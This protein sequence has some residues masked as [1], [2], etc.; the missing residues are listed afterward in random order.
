MHIPTPAEIDEKRLARLEAKD[1]QL[2]AAI[3]SH[4]DN[5]GYC[6]HTLPLDDWSDSA[7][8]VEPLLVK[9]GWHCIFSRSMG[10]LTIGVFPPSTSG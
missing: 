9:A 2:L 5:V 3:I 8:V 10:I 6:L 4:L 1:N 7:R